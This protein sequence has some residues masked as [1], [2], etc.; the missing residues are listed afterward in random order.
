MHTV[1][2]MVCQNG[3][4]RYAILGTNSASKVG[5]STVDKYSFSLTAEQAAWL[6]KEAARLGIGLPELLRRIIDLARKA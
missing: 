2:V 4:M 1:W 3:I 5:R 6:R